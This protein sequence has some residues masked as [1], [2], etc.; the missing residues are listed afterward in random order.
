MAVSC[1]LCSPD[2]TVH[3]SVVACGDRLEETLT[4][5]KSAVIFTKSQIHLHIFADDVLQIEFKQE[6]HITEVTFSKVVLRL[7]CLHKL[8][9]LA[10]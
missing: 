3:L 7:L 1:A 5:I 9:I 2:S 8:A 10:V 4:M 6:V